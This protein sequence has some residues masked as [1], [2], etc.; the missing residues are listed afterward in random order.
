[1][2]NVRYELERPMVS[3]LEKGGSPCFQERLSNTEKERY[4]GGAPLYAE[5]TWTILRCSSN[6]ESPWLV[7]KKRANEEGARTER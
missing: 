7:H 1:M 4:Y 2:C 3:A 5:G 6:R